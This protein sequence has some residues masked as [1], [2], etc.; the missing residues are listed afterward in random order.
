MPK[1]DRKAGRSKSKAPPRRKRARPA[2]ATGAEPAIEMPAVPEQP[3]PEFDAVA[4]ESAA[5]PRF[6]VVGIGASAGGLEACT[7]LLENLPHNLGAALIIVQHMFSTH[8]SM[9]KDLLRKASKLP[10]AE[11][12]DGM[13]IE[14]NHV[15]VIPPGTQMALAGGRLQLTR[16]PEDSSRF[17]PID[18]FFRSV[19]AY[20]QSRAIGVVLSGTDGDGAVGIRDIK[21]AAGITIA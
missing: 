12:T 15:Y 5:L 8:E 17:K 16:P 7:E 20:A 19:A 1:K 13:P 21:G 18:F 14:P 4:E 2:S 11:V 9:L 6:P 10:V 3:S